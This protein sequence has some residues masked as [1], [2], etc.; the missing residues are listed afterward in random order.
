M[1][2]QRKGNPRNTANAQMLSE[3]RN[4]PAA[5]RLAEESF[6]LQDS[7][8]PEAAQEAA[9]GLY[10]D[11]VFKDARA[12]R[13]LGEA[14]SLYGGERYDLER[15]LYRVL[16]WNTGDATCA[17]TRG[18][19]YIPV[20]SPGYAEGLV[21]VTELRLEGH[22]HHAEMLRQVVDLADTRLREADVRLRREL[23]E[24]AA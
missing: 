3:S 1:S 24:L 7:D 23:R 10:L 19:A 6:A 5:Q 11:Q 14:T 16:A 22:G 13:L 21:L 9:Y 12:E 15:G 8:A 20:Q 18:T 4:T 17:M 2:P